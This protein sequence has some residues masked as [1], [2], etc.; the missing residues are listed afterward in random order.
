MIKRDTSYSLTA[1][2]GQ[3]TGEGHAQLRDIALEI[4]ITNVL[5]FLIRQET[6]FYTLQLWILQALSF[7]S[8]LFLSIPITSK[9]PGNGVL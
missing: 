3:N 7:W 1:N 4:H 6:P 2:L 9:S 5:C 8:I